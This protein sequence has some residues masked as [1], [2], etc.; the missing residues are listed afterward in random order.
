TRWLERM[1]TDET[2][3]RKDLPDLTR[4]M[5]A[6]GVRIGEALACY[7]SDVDYAA[8]TVSVDH[9]V[10]RVKGKGLIRKSTKSEAGERTLPLPSWALN[11][12]KARDAEAGAS[13]DGPIF[14]DSRG[15][16]PDPANTPRD[17]PN[18]RGADGLARVRSH[19]FRQ[20]AATI[21]AA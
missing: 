5:I 16:L 20:T 21:L 14:P 3:V 9:T 17:L 15:G 10:I 13:E 2:A 7:K 1:E 18:A 11:M 8:G 4:F 12:L 6:T 19:V